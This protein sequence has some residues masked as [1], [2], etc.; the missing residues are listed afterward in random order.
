[1][2]DDIKEYT[3]AE[4]ATVDAVGDLTEVMNSGIDVRGNDG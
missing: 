3:L 4:L 1:M 2:A